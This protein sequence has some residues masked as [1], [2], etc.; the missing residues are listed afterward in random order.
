MLR[1]VLQRTAFEDS[2]KAL[3]GTKGG[4]VHLSITPPIACI[5]IDNP[6]ASNSFTGA[7][8]AQLRDAVRTLQQ[9]PESAT[10]PTCLVLR[11]NPACPTFCG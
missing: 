1:R 2:L 7:M 4:Q 10:G 9:L 6:L 3:G 11:A 8:M 5:T